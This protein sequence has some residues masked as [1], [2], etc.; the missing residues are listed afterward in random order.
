MGLKKDK[1]EK[2]ILR[3]KGPKKVGYGKYANRTF[4]WLAKNHPD[5]FKQLKELYYNKYDYATR[6]NYDATWN[7]YFVNANLYRDMKDEIVDI[8]V[9]NKRGERL[10]I[11][12]VKEKLKEAY[13]N[14]SIA[15]LNEC[16]LESK[17]V[18]R[19]QYDLERDFLVDVHCLR[20]EE[21]YDK[22]LNP[23]LS[24]TPPE[25]RKMVLAESYLNALETL[26]QKEK[27]LGIHTKM[28]KVHIQTYLLHK[29]Q[30]QAEKL[31]FDRL[32]LTEKTD[33]LK[34]IEM[35]RTSNVVHSPLIQS[36]VTV[37]EA[38]IEVQQKTLIEAPIRLSKET[39]VRAE[40]EVKIIQTQGKSIYEVQQTMRES[41]K[42]E[43]EEA[44]KR[45]KNGHK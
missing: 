43:V 45:A 11:E 3:S 19:K 28:F 7:R 17:E 32:T 42:K 10:R 29:K 5:D 9:T 35:T 33:L 39:D 36:E 23:D 20:Y 2:I 13:P 38:V 6:L 34:L 22:A 8:F 44:I 40:E 41:I 27:L 16:E 12:Q 30:K 15:L 4:Y 1:D 25:F 31:N 26:V 24:S 14:I 18:V 37:T 21:L